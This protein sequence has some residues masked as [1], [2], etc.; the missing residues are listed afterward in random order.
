ML[1]AKEALK[2]HSEF[3][4]VFNIDRIVIKSFSAAQ[5]TE[6]NYQAIEISTVS[7]EDYEI[8]SKDYEQPKSSSL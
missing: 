3:L 7:D 4:D 5:M 8:F 6:S 1:E 2:I